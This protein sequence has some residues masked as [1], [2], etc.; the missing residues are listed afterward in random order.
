M[1]LLA[2]LITGVAGSCALLA[3]LLATSAIAQQAAEPG[4][5]IRLDDVSGGRLVVIPKWE[6]GFFVSFEIPD[7]GT[8]PAVYVQGSDGRQ[9]TKA[10]VSLPDA[11]ENGLIDAAVSPQ[12]EVAVTGAASWANGR[13]TAYFMFIS[14]AGKMLQL[15][16][17]SPFSARRICFSADGTLWA[18]GYELDD[19][20]MEQASYNLL[21][22]YGRDGVLIKSALPRNSF[23]LPGHSNPISQS[24]LA[25]SGDLVGVYSNS[26]KEWIEVSSTTGDVVRRWAGLALGPKSFVI[27]AFLTSS[28]FAYVSA[29]NRE[30]QVRTVHQLDRSTGTWLAV[31]NVSHRI[32]GTDRESVLELFARSEIRWVRPE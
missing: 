6:N 10:I 14:K 11:V 24:F 18:L 28:G 3:T 25:T 2:R 23:S 12:G 16:R 4:K 29:E 30:T 22:H 27:G 5:Q 32:I 26:T 15:V 21:K 31:N 9:L 17:T 13:A 8:T 1:K 20:G 7:G 19:G